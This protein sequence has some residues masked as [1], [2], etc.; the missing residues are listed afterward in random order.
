VLTKS[1]HTITAATNVAAYLYGRQTARQTGPQFTSA[2]QLADY[3]LAVL[4]QADNAHTLNDA[5][6]ARIVANCAKLLGGAK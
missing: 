3:A 4:G 1:L 2:R 5:T 6:V